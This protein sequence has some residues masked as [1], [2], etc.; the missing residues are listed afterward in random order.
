MESGSAEEYVVHC[1]LNDHCAPSCLQIKEPS[2]CGE[3]LELLLRKM[4]S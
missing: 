3:S 2:D 4:P 1:V